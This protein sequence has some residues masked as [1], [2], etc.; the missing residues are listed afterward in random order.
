M[1]HKSEAAVGGKKE[2]ENY[3]KNYL[4]LILSEYMIVI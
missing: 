4:Y 3:V 1:S 2:S